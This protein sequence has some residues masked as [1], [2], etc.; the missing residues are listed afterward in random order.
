MHFLKPTS[1]ILCSLAVLFALGGCGEKKASAPKQTQLTVTTLTAVSG[2]QPYVVDLFGQTEGQQAVI[3]YPQ[4]TGPIISRDY[5]EGALVKK[6]DKL[7]TIDP[8][9]FDAALQSAKAAVA[10]AEVSLAKASREAARYT[11]LHKSEAVSEK[12]YTDAVSELALC[13]ANLQAAQAKQ[14]EAEITLGYTEVKAPVDGIA[15]RALVNPGALVSANSTALTDITQDNLLKVR[16]SLSDNDLHGY[17]VNDHSPVSVVDDRN[18][19]ETPAVIEFTATQIDPE[20]GARS[21]SAV[22]PQSSGL[23]PGQYVTVHLTLGEQDGV[24]LVPQSA[25]RQLSDGTYSVYVYS[26]GKARQRPVTVGRWQGTD[27]IITSGLNDGDEVIIDQIQKLRDKAAV[28]KKEAA[29]N[30]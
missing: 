20:T 23:L 4:V 24:F 12:E 3:V 16:F 10:Q 15:G 14:R 1:I 21:L 5:T 19:Q 8:A 2:S 27:W 18:G 25:V 29:Q 9:P 11:K 6:G 28:N 30:K 7:F 17:S 26:D 22:I 13:K